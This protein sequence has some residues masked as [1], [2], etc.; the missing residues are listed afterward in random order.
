[1]N[2]TC[3]QKHFLRNMYNEPTDSQNETSPSEKCIVCMAQ[4]SLAGK[5]VLGW[6]FTESLV[7]PLCIRLPQT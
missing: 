4:A 5:Y 3:Y 6:H 2:Y 7:H 1:M